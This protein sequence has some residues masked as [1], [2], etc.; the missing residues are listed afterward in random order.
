MKK[1]PSDSLPDSWDFD[2]EFL[3]NRTSLPPYLPSHDS[4]V[5]GPARHDD[6]TACGAKL[7]SSQSV[8]SDEC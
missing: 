7:I 3:S 4:P 6:Q 5:L 8:T 1:P 2:P